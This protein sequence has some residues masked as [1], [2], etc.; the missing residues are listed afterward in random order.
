MV[1]AWDPMAQAWAAVVREAMD[2]TGRK[3]ASEADHAR[4]QEAAT[5]AAETVPA[6]SATP[7]APARLGARLLSRNLELQLAASGSDAQL[8]P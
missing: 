7:R 4:V 2:V 8:A 6:A 5:V 3:H 1:K